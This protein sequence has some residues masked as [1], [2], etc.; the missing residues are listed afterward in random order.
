MIKRLPVIALCVAMAGFLTGYF[1]SNNRSLRPRM[2]PAENT[3][4][5]VYAEIDWAAE[6]PSHLQ[7]CWTNLDSPGPVTLIQNLRGVR[8][9]EFTVS[10][11]LA[12]R[13]QNE[14]GPKAAPTRAELEKRLYEELGLKRPQLASRLGLSVQ[15]QARVDEILN[16][17]PKVPTSL[18]SAEERLLQNSTRAQRIAFLQKHLTPEELLDYRIAEDGDPGCVPITMFIP[19]SDDEF[20]RCFAILDGQPLTRANGLLRPD[21]EDQIRK[22]LGT[23]YEAYA[24]EI[25]PSNYSLRFFGL[26]YN[27]PPEQI[28]KLKRLRKRSSSM[29]SESYEREVRALLDNDEQAKD[30]FTH[31]DCYQPFQH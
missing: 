20:K 7:V 14:P 1:Y 17:V 16:R 10:Y 24:M 29:S 30:F 11:I 15:K 3:N 9:P 19:L 27:L 31:P 21:L 12:S 26:K 25:H 23:N 22:A 2:D 8:C 13:L 6:R 18:G 4:S 5:E 28:E